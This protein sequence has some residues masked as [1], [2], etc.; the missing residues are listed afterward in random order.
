MTKAERWAD[1]YLRDQHACIVRYEL[2]TKMGDSI[3]AAMFEKF[4]TETPTKN[5]CP[6]CD[7][8]KE[9][10]RVKRKIDAEMAKARLQAFSD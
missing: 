3:L 10:A 5:L 1:D 8:Q 7:Y 6:E 2:K 4:A 9:F